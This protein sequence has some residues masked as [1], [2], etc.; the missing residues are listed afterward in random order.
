MRYLKQDDG[1]DRRVLLEHRDGRPASA[2]AKF[3]L[4]RTRGPSNAMLCID[5]AR[6]LADSLRQD[7]KRPLITLQEQP[8][9][10]TAPAAREGVGSTNIFARGWHKQLEL[11][12]Y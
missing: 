9:Y 11:G 7:E 4:T 8:V 2:R 6:C 10:T 5:R 12:A 1:S 3:R